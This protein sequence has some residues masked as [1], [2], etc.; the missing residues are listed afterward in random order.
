MWP[1]GGAAAYTG[2]EDDRVRALPYL[3]RAR[4]PVKFP[5]SKRVRAVRVGAAELT[6]RAQET[7]AVPLPLFLAQ[8]AAALF[9]APR[10][11]ASH[12]TTP[13]D[14]V[15]E[16]SR[17]TARR[18]GDP[19]AGFALHELQHHHVLPADARRTRVTRITFAR[20]PRPS[21]RARAR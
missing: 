2:D 11:R 14:D 17:A 16:V 6:Q 21:F 9:R 7:L 15:I 3:P 13:A 8:R 1:E 5:R 19:G 4:R 12:G 20:L 10:Q 18:P